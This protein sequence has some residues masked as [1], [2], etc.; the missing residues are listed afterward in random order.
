MLFMLPEISSKFYQ[1]NSLCCM[2]LDF[3]NAFNSI[4][5]ERMQAVR[6]S[7]SS[8]S[9]LFSILS[10]WGNH[11]IVSTQGAQQGDPLG[12]LLFC[13][14]IHRPCTSLKSAFCV[15]YL[16]DMTI[17]GDLENILHDLNAI[18]KAKILWLSLNNEKSEIICEDAI[19]RGH[20]CPA[21]C[22]ADCSRGSY[23]A[24]IS[25]RWDYLLMHH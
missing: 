24:T 14:S 2:K 15:M 4:Q 3:C 1:I 9:I 8:F 10:F 17:G 16:D 25:I 21:R 22:P 5:K 6:I 23:L 13:L 12:P 11:T 20:S 19:V 18:K 7:D